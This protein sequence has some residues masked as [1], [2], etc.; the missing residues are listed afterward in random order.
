MLYP[1]AAMYDGTRR[2]AFVGSRLIPTTAIVLTFSTIVA[3]SAADGLSGSELST[4][5]CSSSCE[6]V[7]PAILHRTSSLSKMFGRRI[8]P[9]RVGCPT[10]SGKFFGIR[11]RRHC[12]TGHRC[13]SRIRP[14]EEASRGARAGGSEARSGG[15]RS[16]A[17]GRPSTGEGGSDRGT[18]GARRALRVGSACGRA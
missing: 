15:A 1:F 17:R 10:L 6:T 11:N 13:R 8:H 7:M 5:R 3:S 18:G 4:R 9:D 16:G 12:R 14:G 2:A